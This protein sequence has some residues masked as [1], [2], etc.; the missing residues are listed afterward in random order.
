M[1]PII[2]KLLYRIG[3]AGVATIFRS[4]LLDDEVSVDDAS[5]EALA[6][7]VSELVGD[8]YLS[9][10]FHD[11]VKKIA[12]DVARRLYANSEAYQKDLNKEQLERVLTQLEQAVLMTCT[13]ARFVARCNYDADTVF[14]R[15]K[16]NANL[17]AR[18]FSARAVNLGE[19]V[20]QDLSEQLVI[21][22]NRFPTFQQ[23][24]FAEVLFRLDH[25]TKVV[26]EVLSYI[27]EIRRS[28]GGI[29]PS[30]GDIEQF[31]SR[32]RFRV[33]EQN[34]ALKIIGVRDTIPSN[35]LDLKMLPSFVQPRLS[36]PLSIE[37]ELH[38]SRRIVLLGEAGYGKTTL[39]RWLAI[40][41][42]LRKLDGAFDEL[43]KSFPFVI[44]LRN[45]AFRNK[46][47]PGPSEFLEFV[48]S[49]NGREPEG[50]VAKKIATG[51]A[52]IL[53]DGLD[54]L[55]R[56]YI[57]NYFIPWLTD[58][59]ET[60]DSRVIVT[61]RPHVFD[62]DVT[63][64]QNLVDNHSFKTIRIEPMKSRDITVFIKAWHKGLADKME[65]SEMEYGPVQASLINKVRTTPVLRDL[66]QSPLL[67][68]L[69]CA[70]HWHRSTLLPRS[71][72][73]LYQAILNMLLDWRE[74]RDERMEGTLR[75]HPPLSLDQ[76]RNFAKELAWNVLIGGW[77]DVPWERA[78]GWLETALEGYDPRP[79]YDGG[80]RIVNG[81]DV[82]GY[83][84]ERAGLLR[85]NTYKKVE[86][87]HV[88][89]LQ[90]LGAG[91]A[92]E[93]SQIGQIITSSLKDKSVL[94][95]SM[96]QC[97]SEEQTESIFGELLGRIERD[98]ENRVELIKLAREAITYPARLS[99]TVRQSVKA[100]PSF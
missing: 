61:S 36:S 38:G 70:L 44:S 85:R 15:I 11:T 62:D 49:R 19:H 66:A 59:V 12:R 57:T 39:V 63:D 71:L 17:T 94:F 83:L 100:L 35:L 97:G 13:S 47:L 58:L 37:G 20:L 10:D 67:C 48:F 77:P 91:A 29:A 90:F 52:T 75:D 14:L 2:A 26:T 42:A 27:Q 53:I 16:E 98:E 79:K 76:W 54:E 51:K 64:W 74:H 30:T 43:N 9:D 86:F 6:D 5:L 82:L 55:P 78:S 28:N 8:K 41:I 93:R 56:S 96:L 4:W 88:T 21:I 40:N 46:P 95:F 60:N 80:G 68:A 32:Y 45:Y 73:D 25:V 34:E 65:M 92:L 23:E 18:N 7:S 89:F 87:T 1:D 22:C 3:V 24:S 72:V 84:V 31:E 50:W 33:L 69:L 99:P 81:D